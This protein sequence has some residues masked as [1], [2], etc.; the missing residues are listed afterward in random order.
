M[1]EA[2]TVAF[3]WNFVRDFPDL[4]ND[5]INRPHFLETITDILSGENPVVFLEGEE[6]DG[7]TTTL[8]QFCKKYPEHSFSLFIKPASR[9]AYSLDYLRLALAEQFHWYLFGTSLNKEHLDA[10]EF[11]TLVLRVRRKQRSA[12]LYFVV[13]GLHQIP[14]EDQRI[15]AQIFSEVLP[16][17]VDNCRFLIT[18][19]QS[20]LGSH[21]KS[22]KSKP[23]QQL[24]FRP[25]ESRAYLSAASLTDEETHAV[26]LLCKGVPGRLAAVRR[27]LLSGT[28]LSTILDSE[29]SRYLEFIRL[30][31]AS[32]ESMPE[33]QQQIVATVAFSKKA[34]SV[35]E[36]AGISKA[37]ES[38]VTNVMQQCKFLV[39][40]AT[41]N[42]VELISESHRRFAERQLERLKKQSLNSQVEYLLKNPR[43]EVAL[44]F[45]PSYYEALNQ[46][47]AIVSLLSKDH[48]VDLLESTQSIAALKARAALG[49]RSAEALKRTHEVFKFALHKNIFITVSTLEGSEAEI[50]ALVAL[51]KPQK[52]LALAN[53]AAAKEDRLSLL[54]KYARKLKERRGD[55]EP[56]LLAFIKKLADEVEFRELGDKAM[57]I[58]ANVLIFEPNLAIFIIEE[59]MKGESAAKKD[60]AFTQLS[61]SG[62][63]SK[64]TDRSQIENKARAKIS[65]EALQEVARSFEILAET[66]NS[67]ELI[68]TVEKMT[69]GHQIFFLRSFVRLRKNDPKILDIIEYSL[70]SIIRETAYTPKS[71]DLT[72]LASP[73]TEEIADLPRLRNL[74]ARFDSQMGLL[75]NTAFSRDLTLLQLRLAAAENQYDPELA[76]DRIRQ[77][78]YD[79]A[80]IRTPEVQLECYALM[81]SALR[82]LDKLGVFE[83]KDG[84]RAV[85]K[86]DLSKLLD[87]ILG[88]TGDNFSAVVGVL[89]ALAADD[90]TAAFQLS[91]RLNTE[92]RRD[93]AYALVARV[94][95]SLPFTEVNFNAVSNSLNLI[96]D[97][98]AKSRATR[99]L[100]E[101]MESN[102][103]KESWLAHLKTFKAF[104][105]EPSVVCEWEIW[106]FK[107]PT[108]AG[109][110]RSG[111]DFQK[112]IEAEA[113][114]IESSLTE[115]DVYFRAAEALSNNA[116]KLAESFYEKGEELK[117]RV[118]PNTRGSLSLFDQ[119]LS[120]I[121][122]ALT[123]MARAGVIGDDLLSRYFAL[124][125]AMPSLLIRIRV[126]S[127]LAERMWCAKRGDL[128]DRIVQ[129]QVRPLLEEAKLLNE[130]TY[131]E[132]IQ[133]ALPALNV[134]HPLTAF[135]LVEN[136]TDQRANQALYDAAMLR[137]RKLPTSEP[138]FKGKFDR[139]KI[140][141]E[142]VLDIIEIL[143]RVK[144]DSMFFSI[145][146][147]FVEGVKDKSNKLKF[148]A[149]QKADYAV[150]CRLIIGA[151]LPDARNIT[152]P[153]FLVLCLALTYSLEETPFSAWENLVTMTEG[154]G[155][156][157]DRGFVFMNLAGLLP[158]KYSSHRKRFLDKTIALFDQIPSPLDR[159]SHFEDYAK[160]ASSNDAVLSAKETLRRAMQL[161]MEIEDNS[162]AAQ[163]RRQLID[164]AD[165]ITPAFA[166]ELIELIDDDPARA[167]LKADTKKAI[168]LVKA[169]REVANTKIAKDAAACDIDLLPEAAWL[170]LAALQAGQLETKP[171]DVMM[172]YVSRAADAS[173]NDAYPVLSWHLENAARK[174]HSQQDVA[175]HVIPVCEALMLS[176][177]LAKAIV[178]QA[179]RQFSEA[180]EDPPEGMMV[181]RKGRDE[182]LSFIGQ[183]L[184]A[185]TVD[186]IKFCDPYFSPKDLPLLRIILAQA[187]NC[188][189]F[190]LA[191]KSELRK[192][193]ALSE[194]AFLDAWKAQS[195]QDPPETE[196]IAISYLDS[197]KHVIHDRWLLT[198]GNGLRIGTSFNSIGEG[199]L[200]EISEM[201][202]AS[203]SA[204]EVQL[205]RFIGR[206]RIVDGA[207]IQYTSFTF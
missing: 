41:T 192:E 196:I 120:L 12:A 8:A 59:A 143:R 105:I 173:M 69:A 123:P 103:D 162:Q 134:W 114:K 35:A 55:V 141:K 90:P 95:A 147:P 97:I 129:E 154:I 93:M 176:T 24:R 185:N 1:A 183:W 157:A 160:E 62:S 164:I 175:A 122:R 79:V 201:G 56:E 172:E 148:T 33:L 102:K 88:N 89:K 203:A 19:N 193:G 14:A 63:L 118:S 109:E 138:S 159:L 31:F 150:R 194:E 77:A 119:C 64:L 60:Q 156:V 52:A 117:R 131:R 142:D 22:I 72:D 190:V 15:V 51:G 174:Y 16:M 20:V 182:A 189:V 207:R 181:C 125:A 126:Y 26:H 43:S 13:D 46:Q 86:S 200:S 149:Q 179:F 115:I 7:A 4:S 106:M 32:L 92:S 78:Y 168:A 45:L 98:D 170:N 50:E 137:L 111:N 6:G 116:P 112:L 135:E 23:Y 76:R 177:E 152:H 186:Y 83:E 3:N 161:S 66:F 39:L 199:K 206:Q 25:E 5:L 113:S 195:F 9:F 2:E 48:Y 107:T 49:A 110:V 38:D 130:Q 178:A 139:S 74:V 104:L 85:I 165:Q 133:T 40:N 153:G 132:A 29:A 44:R 65:D 163:H 70:D 17:G 145:L 71:K 140:E 99:G 30:E 124:A 57:Q 75:T 121:S 42:V 169:K 151:K 204:C 47:E 67:S 127:D 184:H 36:V 202:S 54:A 96:G 82:T 167:A 28:K 21:L 188:K 144:E 108:S 171:L 187:P 94:V 87:N 58:A 100:L 68:Q 191:S 146:K 34:L 91:G 158:S 61:I 128:A 205:D 11:D 84:F 27:L 155:N 101:I 136:L 53:R 73:F 37:A 81:L 197:D 80:D 180:P 198:N 18:G 166:D 10:S